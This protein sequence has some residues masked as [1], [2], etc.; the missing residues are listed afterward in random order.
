V[1][2]SHRARGYCGEGFRYAIASG[3]AVRDPS[4]R[5]YNRTMFLNERRKM[6]QAWAD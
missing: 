2:T 6:M 4:G 1:Y 3:L 5:A